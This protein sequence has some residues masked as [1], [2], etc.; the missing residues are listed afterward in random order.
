MARSNV[1]SPCPLNFGS[2]LLED[3]KKVGETAEAIE[4]RQSG[5]NSVLSSIATS[6]SESLT[7]ILR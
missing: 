1:D 2:R 3:Q 5:E 7:Q 6:V 4:L